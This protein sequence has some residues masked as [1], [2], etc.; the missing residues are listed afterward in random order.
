VSVLTA[1][2]DFKKGIYMAEWESQKADM[3]VEDLVEKARELQLLRVTKELQQLLKQGEQKVIQP[4]AC[5]V[6]CSNCSSAA[7]ADNFGCVVEYAADGFTALTDLSGASL[8]Y[9]SAPKT[10]PTLR[11]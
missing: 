8:A 11:I 6:C 2:K 1:I 9:R 5:I 7:K 3:V 4:V 10:S